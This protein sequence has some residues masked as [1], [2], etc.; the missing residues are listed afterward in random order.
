MATN[1]LSLRMAASNAGTAP[2]CSNAVRLSVLLAKLHKQAAACSFCTSVSP[3]ASNPTNKRAPPTMTMAVGLSYAICKKFP[4]LRCRSAYVAIFFPRDP[5]VKQMQQRLQYP[6]LDQIHADANPSHKRGS[7]FAKRKQ[8]GIS[9]GTIRFDANDGVKQFGVKR[10]SRW[11]FAFLL[12]HPSVHQPINT[13]RAAAGRGATF[14]LHC[15][16]VRTTW[17]VCVTSDS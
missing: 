13:W 14:T 10:L 16:C 5:I 7:N 17:P 15:D 1:S 2:C 4:A 3:L 11:F 6:I 9:G 12:T 8:L